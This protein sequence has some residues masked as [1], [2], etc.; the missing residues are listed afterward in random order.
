[1]VGRVSEPR[2][3]RIVVPHRADLAAE[4]WMGGAHS[5]SGEPLLPRDL[6]EAWV[7]DCAGDMPAHYRAA[8]AWWAVRVFQDYEELPASWPALAGLARSIGRCLAG[9]QDGHAAEHP[10]APPV[11]LYVVCNQGMNRSGLV[12]GRILRALGLT[13]D[14]ALDVLRRHR[15]GAVNN[16]TFARLI[17]E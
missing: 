9:E 17:R 14:E 3:T 11:R 6:A 1:M 7:V 8:A 16:L 12:M 4:L 10:A 13:G 5:A 2:A 15:P